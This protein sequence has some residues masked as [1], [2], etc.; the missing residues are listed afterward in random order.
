MERH[1]GLRLVVVG[2]F[3]D[4]QPLERNQ[5][6]RRGQEVA[7]LGGAPEGIGVD[8]GKIVLGFDP[9]DLDQAE[10]AAG[11]V[12]RYAGGDDALVDESKRTRGGGRA[13]R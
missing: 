3:L 10:R 12:L 9:R 4:G 5:Q 8:V 2:E 6:R 7:E 11:G 13:A 1:E